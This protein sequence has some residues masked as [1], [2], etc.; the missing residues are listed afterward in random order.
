MKNLKI[1]AWAINEDARLMKT[2]CAPLLETAEQHHVNV[3]LF[4]VGVHFVEHKQ[5]VGL[6]RDYLAAQPQLSETIYVCLDGADTLVNGTASQLVE[7]FLQH[8]T[9]ILI[10]AE[11][12]FTHQFELF[13]ER[14][15]SI[16]SPYR[17]VNAGTFMGFGDDLLRMLEEML[18]IDTRMPANDQ[19]LMGMWVHQKFDQPQLVKLDVGSEVFWVTTCDWE[20]IVEAGSSEC[21]T[22]P[23]TRATP[24]IIHGIGGNHEGSYME[25]AFRLQYRAITNRAITEATV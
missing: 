2:M 22:N 16:E 6:L 25:H 17:Y 21:V 10:S 8:E 15:D 14:F 12:S 5:R 19:G 24:V 13:R 7:K 18:V 9:R 20:A 1:L 3:E 11:R 23:E 4:G